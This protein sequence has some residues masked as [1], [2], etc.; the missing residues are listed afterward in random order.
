VVT[1]GT[2]AKVN[3]P[4]R[5]SRDVEALI[6]ALNDGT[7]DIIATDH[8]PHTVVEKALPM[9]EAP[10]GISGLETAF[11]SL[12]GLVHAEKVPMDTLITRLTSAPASILGEKLGVLGTLAVGAL[13]DVVLLDPAK[14][15]VV[16]PDTFASKGRNTPLAGRTL[17]GK[18]MA[19]ISRAKI[20]YKDDSLA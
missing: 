16:A 3:P 20:V 13:A 15:W 6:E 14:E 9:E 8:A 2:N 12:M 18:V 19:A 1:D 17:K 4:L 7:I 5:T 11:G 10:F